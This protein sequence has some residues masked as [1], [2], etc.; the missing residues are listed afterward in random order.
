MTKKTDGHGQE[1]T[2]DV[3][4]LTFFESIMGKVPESVWNPYASNVSKNFRLFADQNASTAFSIEIPHNFCPIVSDAR[5]TSPE[6][7]L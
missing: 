3:L 7:V 6:A 4:A 1:N 5:V 2:R